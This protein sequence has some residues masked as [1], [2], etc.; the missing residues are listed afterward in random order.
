MGCENKD[1]DHYPAPGLR[2]GD[3]SKPTGSTVGFS[4]LPGTVRQDIY[5]RVLAVAHPIYL[6][7]DFG[8]RVESF[9]PDKPKRWIALLYVNRQISGEAKVV[10]Y[11]DNNFYVDGQL[12]K[13]WHPFAIFLG[14]HRIFQCDFPIPPLHQLPGH[15]EVTGL[16]P[17]RSDKTAFTA[18]LLFKNSAPASAHWKCN[19]AEKIL[20]SWLGHARK[21]RILFGTPWHE[22]MRS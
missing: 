16:T 3:A 14:L 17:S 15:G 21:T 9:A 6:F 19:F 1:K 5:K 18:W 11:G 8:P 4:D 12:A 7:R 22:L 13:S 2:F 20:D 10:L